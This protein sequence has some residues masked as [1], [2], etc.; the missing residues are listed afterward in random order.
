VKSAEEGSSPCKRVLAWRPGDV[1]MRLKT[2]SGGYRRGRQC[3]A[4][5][6]VGYYYRFVGRCGWGNFEFA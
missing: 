5:L 4:G 3:K 1:K 2:A 6:N